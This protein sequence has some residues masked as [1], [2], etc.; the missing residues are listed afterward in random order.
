MK[1]TVDLPDDVLHRA[2]IVAA[3]RRTT[4][5]ELFISGLELV[6]SN[7]AKAPVRREALDRLHQGLRL[8]GHPLARE[9]T[10][11]RR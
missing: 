10:H 9:Q 2:K 4:L 5:K 3:Q 6:I 7:D 8:G 1:T 11:E